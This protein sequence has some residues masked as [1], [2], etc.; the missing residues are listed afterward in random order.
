MLDAPQSGRIGLSS[1][2]KRSNPL[3]TPIVTRIPKGKVYIPDELQRRVAGNLA[4]VDLN[5]VQ[6]NTNF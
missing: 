2:A 3:L 4:C 5:V 6:L 1:T